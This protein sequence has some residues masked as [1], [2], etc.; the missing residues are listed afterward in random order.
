MQMTVLMKKGIATSTLA[1]CK[2]AWSPSGTRKTAALSFSEYTDTAVRKLYTDFFLEIDS[3][4]FYVLILSYANFIQIFLKMNSYFFYVL[5][6]PYA[7]F[8][9]IF[10]EMNGYFFFVLVRMQT[11]YRFF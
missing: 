5:I 7:N 9:E 3:Y 6:L 8:I 11:L 1:K 2:L 4:F 10:L